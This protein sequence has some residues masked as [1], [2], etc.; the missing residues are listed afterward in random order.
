MGTQKEFLQLS[1]VVFDGHIKPVIDKKFPLGCAAQAHTYLE[2]KEQ[3]G[4]VILET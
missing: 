1:Q 4:K 2:R 3:I